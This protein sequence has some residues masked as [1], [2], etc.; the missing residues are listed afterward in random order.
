MVPALPA[1]D[2]VFGHA[3]A[4]ALALVLALGSWSKLSDLDSFAFAVERYRLLPATASRVAGFVLPFV[5]ALAAA[6]LVMPHTRAGGA[7]LA[8]LLLA[9][10]TGAVLVNLLRGRTDIDCGCGGPGHRQRL[11][12][13]LVVRNS[14]LLIGCGLTIAPITA[15]PLV[16]L[17]AFTATFAAAAL[18]LLY[19]A[20]DELLSDPQRR[21]H[22]SSRLPSP[23][24][25]G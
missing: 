10:V 14:L 6:L 5:E 12:W 2:P 1:L 20:A 8:A 17:D 21:S 7:W 15:R 11:S 24:T 23:E 16:W 3:V 4:G 13:W 25:R 22:E 18:W 9:L 19:A